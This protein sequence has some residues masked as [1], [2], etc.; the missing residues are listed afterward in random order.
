MSNKQPQKGNKLQRLGAG[1]AALL[2]TSLTSLAFAGPG[3]GTGTT[4]DFGGIM[5]IICTVQNFMSGPIAIALGIVILAIGGLMIAF[6]GKR[7]IPFVIWGIIGVSIALAAPSLFNTLT[8]NTERM[9]EGDR[10]IGPRS[11]IEMEAPL[12][13]E[14][15][16]QFN[17]S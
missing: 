4:R 3:G 6:G 1:F 16:V 8:G 14:H 5:D 2:L 10:Y 13:A 9:C 17:L 12:L 7:S 15:N 11:S